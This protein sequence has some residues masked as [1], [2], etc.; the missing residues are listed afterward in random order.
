M[1]KIIISEEELRRV[2]YDSTVKVLNEGLKGKVIGSE[3]RC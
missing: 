2:V 1:S 3:T